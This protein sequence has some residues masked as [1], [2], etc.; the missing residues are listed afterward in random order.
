MTTH[1]KLKKNVATRHSHISTSLGTALRGKLRKLGTAVTRMASSSH[2]LCGLARIRAGRSLPNQGTER[3]SI[4]RH[5]SSSCDRSFESFSDIFTPSSL[6][7]SA[8][9]LALDHSYH[10]AIKHHNKTRHA[11]VDHN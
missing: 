7:T 8:A 9:P 5:S 10:Q 2:R 3:P 1:S 4:L 11:G 6:W